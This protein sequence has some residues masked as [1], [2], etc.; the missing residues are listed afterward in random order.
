MDVLLLD[1]WLPAICNTGKSIRTWELL[2]PAAKKHRITYLAH[3][4]GSTQ[5]ENVRKM[6][7]AGFE[8][9]CV[10][11][12]RVYD[13]LP[14]MLL[15]AIPAMLDRLPI[16]V[17]RHFSPDYA[18]AVQKLVTERKFDLVHVE[19]S[20]YGVYLPLVEPLPTFICTHNVEFLSWRRLYETA[21]NPVWMLLGLHEFRKMY[22]FE[23]NAYRNVDR[24]S[25]VS[26][27]DAELIRSEFGVDN[28][29]VI[30]NGVNIAAYDE[31][32]NE[33]KPNHLVYCGS[34]D[35]SVNQ[36]A[37]EYFLRR[38]FPLI[39]ARKPETTFCV[40]GR[41]P[42]ASFLKWQNDHVTF[43]GAL[44][45]VRR[46]LK[47]ATLEIVPL[48]IGGGSRLKILEAFA[49][50]VPVLSTALGAEGLDVKHDT[51]IVLA[52]TPEDFADRCVELLDDP[53]RR[54]RLITEGRRT[55]DERYDWSRLS[56]LVENAWTQTIET[57]K[58]RR[59][60]VM[61]E[62]ERSAAAY[63]LKDD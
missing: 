8:V 47:E 34:M 4:D 30:P 61:Q 16:A 56:P 40:I 27:P 49:A 6:E 1:E 35:A 41:H 57:A 29:D 13:S 18:A 19:W 10:P 20:H 59:S 25:A 62:P 15:G 58:R 32:P 37:V 55:V 50:N 24:L 36:D 23:Q 42:P 2:A 60:F 31:I 45:D 21:R 9:V 53:Q 7:A 5:P 22:R 28:V 54:N 51:N 63:P 11:R 44:P 3:V 38:I 12:R 39:L 48:R 46:A 26:G 33:P 52:D 17:R 43:T 14:A